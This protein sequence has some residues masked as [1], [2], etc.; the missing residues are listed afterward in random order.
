MCLVTQLSPTLCDPMDCSPPGF[1]VHG[2]SPG[3]NAGVGCYAILQGTFPTQGLN[4]GLMHC[5]RILYC[6]SHQG[7][8]RTL[9]WVAYPF[10]M[11][12]SRPRNRTGVFCI[13]G[14]FFTSWASIH[15]SVIWVKACGSNNPCH[16]LSTVPG[17]QK[18]VHKCWLL[19]LSVIV[20][21]DEGLCYCHNNVQ[22]QRLT[23]SH[24]HGFHCRCWIP[25]FPVAPAVRGKWKRSCSV[26]SD[27]L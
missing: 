2:D 26:M 17:K 20:D 9:K 8:S 22:F 12:S 10:S 15:K 1:T 27:S 7:S 19:L 16:K 13:A 25:G 4:P 3:K 14:G 6:L 24:R 21:V 5:R 23:L 11:G 18:A